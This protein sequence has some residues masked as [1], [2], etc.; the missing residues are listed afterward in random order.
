MFALDDL[1]DGL[2]S[3]EMGLPWNTLESRHAYGYETYVTPII[4]TVSPE[5]EDY[6]NNPAAP[7]VE[8]FGRIAADGA[9]LTIAN[10]V[11]GTGD[12]ADFVRFSVPAGQQLS[13]FELKSYTSTDAVAFIGLQAG[14]AVT[15]TAQNASPLKGYTHFGSGAS[16][17][18]VG[19]NL[20]N[21]LGGPLEAGDYSLW[22]QQLGAATDYSFEL[23]TEV[24]AV[25]RTGSVGPDSL[26]G[27]AGNDTLSGVGGSDMLEGGDGNDLLDGGA[28]IDTAVYRG[29]RED[30]IVGVN[31][32]GTLSVAFSGPIIQI[33]PPPLT[34]GNDTLSGIERLR[35]ADK[36]LALDTA[37]NAGTVAKI[38]GAVFGKAEVGNAAYAGIGLHFLDALA[39][40]Y[41]QLMQL[42][43]DAR[44]GANPTHTAVVDLLYTNVVG[45]PPDA[46]T[47]SFYVG[48]LDR[49]EHSATSLGVLAA[50]TELNKANVDL[51]GLGSKG[52]EFIPFAG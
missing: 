26:K 22:I 43:I 30:Y 11:G 17:A 23:R 42:A 36:S 24:P 21:K 25:R 33:Y 14:N 15:A 46:A 18:G 19:A 6:S 49:K 8:S 31:K 10:R 16:G 50:E 7:S 48:L 41:E 44:L 9:T 28:D 39:Y 1:S 5:L 37:G 29:A 3:F 12:N 34:E 47:R 51:V 13:S 45:R 35:F 32:D 4:S 40:S 27:G 52:L 38:L 20:I 2:L